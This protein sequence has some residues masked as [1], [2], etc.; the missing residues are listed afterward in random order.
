MSENV[1][2][3]V[4]NPILC[5]T[6]F[7]SPRRLCADDAAFVQLQGWCRVLLLAGQYDQLNIG[8]NA[9]VEEVARQIESH[10]DAY[11]D[12]AI[13]PP[14]DARHHASR[15][16][17]ADVTACGCKSALI[18]LS[19]GVLKRGQYD[20]EGT[21]SAT[22]MSVAP[23]MRTLCKRLQVS[24]LK[25]AGEGANRCPFDRRNGESWHRQVPR[26]RA[27]WK[28]VVSTAIRLRVMFDHLLSPASG[29]SRTTLLESRALRP[30]TAAQQYYEVSSSLMT[31]CSEAYPRKRSTAPLSRIPTSWT[32]TEKGST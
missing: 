16:T 11:S 8:R 15:M 2:H 17:A 31:Y 3:T 30:K 6:S 21:E 12:A 5:F 18:S 10:V 7:A 28:G 14:Q 26:S 19:G 13:I 20:G 24:K 22:E 4:G 1:Q 27:C 9:C 25:I 29:G 32:L 23:P